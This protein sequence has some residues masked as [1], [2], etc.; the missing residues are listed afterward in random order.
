MCSSDLGEKVGGGEGFIM[1]RLDNGLVRFLAGG[2]VAGASVSTNAMLRNTVSLTMLNSGYKTNIIP[3]R[4]TATLDIRLLPHVE[5]EDF[6][7]DLKTVVN[8]DR[9]KF[10]HKRTCTFGTRDPSFGKESPALP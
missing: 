2:A 1:E 7:A 8:D 6:I 10:I 5:P 9:V 3:E 4:A